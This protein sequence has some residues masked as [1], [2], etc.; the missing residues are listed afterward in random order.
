M[1]VKY[2]DYY[3]ILGV[4]KSSTKEEISKAYK[5]LARKYHPDLNQN[6]AA[7]EEKF[8]EVNEAH[9][10]LKDD[11]KRKLYDTLGADWEQGQRFRQGGQGGNPFGNGGSFFDIFEEIFKQNN[12]GGRQNPFGADPFGNFSGRGGAGGFGGGFGNNFG[13][14]TSYRRGRD[15]ETELFITLEEAVNGGEKHFTIG[16]KNLKVNIPKGVKNGGK[17]RLQ[18]QGH[19]GTPAG[20]LYITLQYAKHKTFEVDGNNLIYTAEISPIQGL[21]GSKILVPTLDSSVEL[22]IPSNSS[23]GR[24][25]R[26]REKGL[27]APN[28]RGDL[29]V[30]ISIALPNFENLSEKEKELWESLRELQESQNSQEETK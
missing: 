16:D 2:K 12:G 18:G 27:G 23:S 4:S 1:S 17:L 25:L 20:D 19:H 28:S 29:Y 6:N 11:E 8:K 22:N 15:I 7:A 13:G 9:E 10:V 24:K 3:Q 14:Q 21:F 26:L 30:K 5:Q